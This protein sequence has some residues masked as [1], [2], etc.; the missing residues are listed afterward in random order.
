MLME[1][2][3]APELALNADFQVRITQMKCNGL[4]ND[5]LVFSANTYYKCH[6]RH[7]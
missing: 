3:C 4:V 2:I 7:S 5:R 1:A 6:A